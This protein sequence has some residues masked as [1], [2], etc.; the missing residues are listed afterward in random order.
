MSGVCETG[1]CWGS[2]RLL[3]WGWGFLVTKKRESVFL[4]TKRQRFGLNMY[5]FIVCMID[6]R[7]VL[8]Y[9][10]YIY[11]MYMYCIFVFFY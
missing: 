1:V 2:L 3:V 7:N 8:L 4:E 10:I 5:I 6:Y 9:V 11:I